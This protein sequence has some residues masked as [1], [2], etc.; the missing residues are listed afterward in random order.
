VNIVFP[1]IFLIGCVF[2][3]VV[4]IYAAPV[5]AAIGLGI[6]LTS[7]PVYFALIYKSWRPVQTFTRKTF[8]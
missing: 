5:D 2:L 8:A 3:V 1:I 6:M 7:V 4:P